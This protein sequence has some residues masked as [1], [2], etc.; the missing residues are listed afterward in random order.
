MNENSENGPV[1]SAEEQGMSLLAEAY[2]MK[3][4]AT[5]QAN[6]RWLSERFP[7]VFDRLMAVDLPMPFFVEDSG[8]VTIRYGKFVG[9]FSDFVSLGRVIL[10][11]FDNPEL[12]PHI[13]VTQEH[14]F[15]PQLS[16]PHQGSPLFYQTVEPTYRV[17][18]LEEFNRRFPQGKRSDFPGFG[19][20]RLPIALVFGSGFGW[21]LDRLVDDYE[22]RH[23][24]IVDTDIERLN[25]SL[26]FT[27]WVALEQRFHDRG[28]IWISWLFETEPRTLV[29]K[30]PVLI[31]KHWP[32][33]FLQGV[34]LFFN[35]YDS[36]VVRDTW[37]SLRDDLWK[38][39]RGWG[40]MDDEL[41]GMRHCILNM[42]KGIPLCTG[43]AAIPDDAVAFVIGAGPS[44]DTLLPI[45]RANQ[46]RAVVISCGSAIYA[47][48]R[49]GIKP[50]F[51][52]EVERTNVTFVSLLSD[53]IK[54]ILRD[55]P[56]VASSI[57]DPAAFSL[58]TKPLMVIKDLD[59]GASVIDFQRN[60]PVFKT[61]PT[62]TN[63]GLDLVLRLGFK[64]A[65]LFGVDLGFRDPNYHHSR[66]SQYY[67]GD[68]DQ[69]DYQKY[70]DITHEQHQTGI[71][72]DGNFSDGIQST[73]F[74]IHSRD[75][76]QIVIREHDA[77]TVFNMNDG[78]LI[79]G[80][81]P[82]RPEDF[83]IA[84]TPASKAAA[85]EAMLAAF[86][87][88]YDVDTGEKLDFLAEQ[89]DAVVADLK[90]RFERE[91]K[92]KMEVFDRISEMHEYFFYARHQEAQIF[93]LVRGSMLHMGRFLYDCITLIPSDAEAI[94]FAR[95]GF[96]LFLRFL[97][98]AR[99]AMLELKG[100]QLENLEGRA[101]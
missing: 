8:R 24:I 33:Y 84:S 46:E 79:K 99:E 2:M 53:K 45:L 7:A 27:D 9:R 95:F 32:P 19:K 85:I 70:I 38:L 94:E 67:T 77:S 57:V 14:I 50:D 62:V 42:Q 31:Y 69:P 5:Y 82:L 26:Y 29:E 93:P 59:M 96:D 98:T 100:L 65:Y 1:Q 11:H 54:D 64:Q 68:N 13:S 20:H 89:L 60:Y 78:A 86:T 97:G 90:L 75:A 44:F 17:E 76:M 51:H 52:V 40:F 66:E 22:M 36:R 48:A 35:D 6:L 3:V 30:L 72:V 37:N 101:G 4:M 56:F 74:F 58:S 21:H 63:G 41:L 25:L 83:S 91:M 92:N 16:S 43:K 12:R 81:V 87:L 61:N 39:Y 73:E 15:D 23:L 34:G 47:L 49:A 10:E 80:A 18:L 71:P 88:D 28:G 55:V